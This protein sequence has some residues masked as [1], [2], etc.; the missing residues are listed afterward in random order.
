MKRYSGETLRNVVLA[1]HGGTGKTT[2][3]EALLFDSGAIDRMGRVEAGSATTDF[4]PDET[5]RHMSVNLALAPCEWREHKINVIDAPGYADFI[6]EVESAMRAADAAI[7]LFPQQDGAWALAQE[8]SGAKTLNAPVE[9]PAAYARAGWDETPIAAVS[10]VTGMRAQ[11]VARI[12]VRPAQYDPALGR[13]RVWSRVRVS[14][15]FEGGAV[16]SMRVPTTL[17][18]A[19]SATTDA[20]IASNT[21]GMPA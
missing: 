20:T 6:G 15:A 7:R 8:K 11:R 21:T 19:G 3:A 10:G 5:R 2:L 17:S 9:D 14:V 4:D 16:A 18:R 13:V 12:V 1:G